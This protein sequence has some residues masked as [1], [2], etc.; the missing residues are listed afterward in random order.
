MRNFKFVL[1]DFLDNYKLLRSHADTLDFKGEVNPYD[2]VEYPNISADVPDVIKNEVISKLGGLFGAPLKSANIFMRLSLDGDI[3][4]HA[5]HNDVIMGQYTFMLYLNRPEHCKG[6]TSF[7]KHKE[8]DMRNGPDGEEGLAAW[9]SDTNKREK[10]DRLDTVK[11]ETNKALAFNSSMMHWAES[12]YAFGGSA[13][14]GR[15]M[16]ICFFDL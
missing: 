2:G 16:L 15:L 12:P 7:V 3:P 1:H 8:L 6:G 9:E 11:M 13:K 5:A 10:W 4:P 14:D